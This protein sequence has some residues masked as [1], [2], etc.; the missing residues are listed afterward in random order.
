F[1]R[2][3]VLF[4]RILWTRYGHR[5]DEQNPDPGLR[6][7]EVVGIEHIRGFTRSRDGSWNGGT[8]YNPEDGGTYH[9]TLRLDGDGRLIIVGRPDVPLVG[10]LLGALFGRITYDRERLS[11]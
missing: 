6:D 7:R 4:G 2:G 3:D 8:L 5:R 10:G 11:P 9:A 1:E